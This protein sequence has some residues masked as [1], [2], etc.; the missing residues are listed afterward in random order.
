MLAG[1]REFIGAVDPIA[2]FHH[3]FAQNAGL[4]SFSIF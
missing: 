1:A 4:G 3:H 2:D